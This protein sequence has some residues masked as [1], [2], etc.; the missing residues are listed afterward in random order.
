MKQEIKEFTEG[1]IIGF[2]RAPID[3]EFESAIV[4]GAPSLEML[5]GI[6]RKIKMYLTTKGHF[7]EEVDN[8]E[9]GIDVKRLATSA[10]LGTIGKSTLVITPEFGPRA[11]FSVIFTDALIEVDKSREFDFCRDCSACIEACPTG[12][13]SDSGYERST[14]EHSKGNTC[15][16]CIEACPVGADK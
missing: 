2:T 12:A 11:R 8:I 14:C 16:L 3:S 4:I 9:E 1:A 7:A 6:T 15:V 10:S 13:I 5:E